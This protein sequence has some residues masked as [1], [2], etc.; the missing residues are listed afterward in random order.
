MT[1]KLVVIISSLKVPKMK[2]IILYEIK[3]LVPNYSC[4]QNPWLGGYC[5]Q[6]PVLCPQ[7]NLLNPRPEQNSWVRQC[8]RPSFLHFR[9]VCEEYL[10]NNR[11]PAHRYLFRRYM[12]KV[13]ISLVY[14]FIL[15][16]RKLADCVVYHIILRNMKYR[17]LVYCYQGTAVAQWLRF[18]AKNRKVTGSIPDDVIGIFNAYNPSDRTMVLVSSQPLTEMST[19]S[20]SWG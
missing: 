11:K 15:S 6:I 12:R 1:N 13:S 19:R 4:L 16:V 9:I 7:L 8:K 10:C 2:K 14:I 5:P 3:F 18:C 20:I 17:Y